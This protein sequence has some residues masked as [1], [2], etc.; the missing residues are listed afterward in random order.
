VHVVT[1]G[2]LQRQIAE[3]DENLCGT[4]LTKAERALFTE[5][6]K[7]AYEALHPETRHGVNQHSSSRQ[8]GDS[9]SRFTA[10]TAARTGQSER[11]VQRDA[12]RGQR[13]DHTVPN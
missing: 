9:S 7:Q 5:R 6:R 8:L 2:E 1:L 4:T 3:C 11:A 13:I 12:T 10:D